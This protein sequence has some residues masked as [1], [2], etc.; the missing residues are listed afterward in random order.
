MRLADGVVLQ[1]RQ[2]LLN[3]EAA[4]QEA[5]AGLGDVVRA[6]YILPR[7]EDFSACWPL[8][9]EAFGV[10]RPAATMI[11]AGL[12]DPAMLIEIEVTARLPA[13]QA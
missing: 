13:A 10:S 5:G 6:R 7:R 2:C 12:L 11:E 4:L 9:R 3:I 8:L 1:C